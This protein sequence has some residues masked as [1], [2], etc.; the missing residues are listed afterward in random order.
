MMSRLLIPL[1]AAAYI[2]LT[3]APVYVDRYTSPPR[4]AVHT[5]SRAAEWREIEFE[6]TGYCSCFSCTGKRLGDADYGIT[7]TGTIA[8][9]GTIAADLDLFPPGTKMSI[10]GYGEGVVSDQGG[11][12]RGYDLD[13]WFSSHE[14]ALAWG[15]RQ[16]R[17]RVEGE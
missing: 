12:I 1:L 14:A 5:V 2:L 6:V 16:A 10:P 17:V 7:A 3:P 9:P 13:V 4:L 8:G 11:G 15:R